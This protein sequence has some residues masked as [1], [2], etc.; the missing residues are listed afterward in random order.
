MAVSEHA[1]G[2]QLTVI[3]TEHTLTANPETTDGVFQFFIDVNTMTL[4]DILEI[5]FKEKA[6]AADT[7]RQFARFTLMGPQVDKLWASPAYILLHG[8]D[9]SIKQTGGAVATYP[10][11]IRKSG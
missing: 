2:A 5:R 7:E 4:G 3:T 10:W 1:S 11:S 9:V 6:R 8:W